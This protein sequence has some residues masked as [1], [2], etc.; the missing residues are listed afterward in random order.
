MKRP[1]YSPQAEAD[2][3][4]ITEYYSAHSPAA[5]VRLLDAITAKCRQLGNQPRQ[6]NPRDNLGAGVRSV[7]VRQYLIFFR[8]TATGVEVVRVLHGS[9]DITPDMF[10]E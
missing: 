8:A 9:R 7:A 3:D 5:G 6:G 10:E 4:A 1:I 2:L